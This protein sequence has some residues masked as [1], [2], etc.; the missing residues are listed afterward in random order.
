MVLSAHRPFTQLPAALRGV[1]LMPQLVSTETPT[2][3][4]WGWDGGGAGGTGGG[5]RWGWA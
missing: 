1:S 3:Q 5:R 2:L 4:G